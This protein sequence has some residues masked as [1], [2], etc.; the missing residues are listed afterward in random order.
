[1]TDLP[2]M[3]EH[4]HQVIVAKW[5]RAKYGPYACMAVPNGA[6]MGGGSKAARQMAKLKSEGLT[7]GAPD[8]VV[9]KMAQVGEWLTADDG[10]EFRATSPIVI[11]MKKPEERD[12]PNGG[13][14]DDQIAMHLQMRRDGWIVIVAYSSDEAIKALEALGL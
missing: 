4:D 8:V 12:K 13:L 9:T 7:K 3:T 6:F 5:L 14:S 11:E 1:M 10:K 2:G